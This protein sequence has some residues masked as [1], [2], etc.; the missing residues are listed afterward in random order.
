MLPSGEEGLDLEGETGTMG[1]DSVSL[2]SFT[3][4]A[5]KKLN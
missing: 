4:N 3:E 5:M 2:L 1:K